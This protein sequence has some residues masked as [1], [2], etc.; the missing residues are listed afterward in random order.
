MGAQMANNRN[1]NR[2]QEWRDKIQTGVLV[3]RLYDNTLGELKNAAGQPI[4]MTQG[5][6]ACAKILL[7]KT[8]PDLKAIEHKIEPVQV[9]HNLSTK[10]RELLNRFYSTKFKELQNDK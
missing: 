1:P 2:G 3:T 5:Q 6:I 9:T 7:A 4:E 10:D 8:I